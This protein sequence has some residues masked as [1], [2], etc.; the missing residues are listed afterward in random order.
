M[1]QHTE[2]KREF[3]PAATPR[4]AN[5]HKVDDAILVRVES[6]KGNGTSRAE[7]NVHMDGNLLLQKVQ[8]TKIFVAQFVAKYPDQS[9]IG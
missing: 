5:V 9:N 6:S 4:N 2:R 1:L 7:F 8:N 3:V